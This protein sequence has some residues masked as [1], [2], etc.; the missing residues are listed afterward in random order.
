MPVPGIGIVAANEATATRLGVEG[1]VVVRTVPGSP[2][3]RAGLRGMDAAAGK[4]GDV[5]V[6]VD[7]NTVRQLSDLTEELE[8]VGIG[9]S[10]HLTLN[11]DGRSVAVD[12]QVEDI[13]RRS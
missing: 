7:G 9:K 12:V 11:R 1:V 13:S 3:A 10:A 6:G 4:I 8:K 5:I 2:A